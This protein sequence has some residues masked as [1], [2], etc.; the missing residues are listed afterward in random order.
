MHP[1]LIKF[2]SWPLYSF[3]FMVALG[4]L[5]LILVALYYARKEG[6]QA[7][8]VLDFTIYLILASALGARL[9]YVIGQWENFRQNP[10]E[11][12]MFTRGGFVLMGGLL[13]GV[14]AALLYARLKNI[15]PLKF[16][17]I[18]TPASILAYAIG[19]IGC[20][21]NGCCFGIPTHS[22]LGIIFPDESLAHSYFPGEAVYPTQ[23]F[24]SAS[25]AL[26]F[27][28]LIFIY[29]AKKRDGFVFFWGLILYSTYRFLIEFIRFSPIHWLTLTPTQWAMLLVFTASIVGLFRLRSKPSV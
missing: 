12:L 1:I 28:I 3:G 17:D 6:I 21:L 10:A 26:A 20:F 15:P 23:L 27:I 4:V 29:R 16:V 18:L 8:L 25:M 9:F 7:E 5:A 14:L 24:S 19:R 2:W 11:I 22:C 13:F